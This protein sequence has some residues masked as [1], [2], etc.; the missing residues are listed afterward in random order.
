MM[1]QSNLRSEIEME[2][3]YSSMVSE[4][5]RPRSLIEICNKWLFANVS[6]THSLA[7]PFLVSTI[8]NLLVYRQHHFIGSGPRVVAF[9]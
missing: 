9:L 5:P 8:V 4:K 7:F 2:A 3:K 1:K 6:M